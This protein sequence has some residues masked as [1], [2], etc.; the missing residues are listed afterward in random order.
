MLN[1]D[2]CDCKMN[3]DINVRPLRSFGVVFFSDLD[4]FYEKKIIPRYYV[5]LKSL[6][7]K[8]VAIYSSILLTAGTPIGSPS[9]GVPGNHP[10]PLIKAKMESIQLSIPLAFSYTL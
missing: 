2:N 7:L 3:Q 10:G 9:R 4:L 5:R 6:K 8:C 1:G